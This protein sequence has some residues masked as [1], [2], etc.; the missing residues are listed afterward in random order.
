MIIIKKVGER[1]YIL[2]NPVNITSTASIVGPKEKAGPLHQYFDGKQNLN[3]CLD[4]INI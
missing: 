3:Q 4:V 1:S 2:A